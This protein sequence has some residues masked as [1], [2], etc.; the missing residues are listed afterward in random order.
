[1]INSVCDECLN[2]YNYHVSE[3]GCWGSSLPCN[4]YVGDAD[5]SFS[6]DDDNDELDNE[7]LDLNQPIILKIF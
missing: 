6:D 3:L 2:C 5:D 7:D 4:S 1:M